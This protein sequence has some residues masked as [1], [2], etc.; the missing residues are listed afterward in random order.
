MNKDFKLHFLSRRPE[1]VGHSAG[2]GLI[3]VF[4]FLA[5]SRH[6]V[7]VN[8]QN[9]TSLIDVSVFEVTQRALKVVK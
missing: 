5:K 1:S 9:L 3:I 8:N 7:T 4:P 6:T 2:V